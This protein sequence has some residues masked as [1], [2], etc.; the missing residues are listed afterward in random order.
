MGLRLRKIKMDDGV[1]IPYPAYL[2]N[3]LMKIVEEDGC[4]FLAFVEHDVEP[5]VTSPRLDSDVPPEVQA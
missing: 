2:H 5:M 4:I 1:T 3:N